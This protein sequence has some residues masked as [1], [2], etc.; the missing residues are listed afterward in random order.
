MQFKDSKTYKNLARSFAGQSQ[1]G[2]RYQLIANQS[3]AEE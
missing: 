2:L 1:A 3:T